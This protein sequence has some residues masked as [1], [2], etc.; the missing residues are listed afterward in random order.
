VLRHEAIVQIPIGRPNVRDGRD[1][2]LVDEPIL[3]RAI[4]PLR[5]GRALAAST[6][7]VFDAN[8]ASARPQL[9]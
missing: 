4:Q 1:A 2:Q 6:R 7:N 9:G 5:C 8:R 3:E